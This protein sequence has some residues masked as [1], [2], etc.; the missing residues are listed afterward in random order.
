MNKIDDLKQYKVF[1]IG[2][3][4]LM[5]GIFITALIVIGIYEWW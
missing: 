4:P 5:I 2:I 3:V 1:G